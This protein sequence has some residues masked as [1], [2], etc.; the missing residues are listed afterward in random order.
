M[1]NRQE[2]EIEISNVAY[3]RYYQVDI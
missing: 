3:I 1:I 2:I